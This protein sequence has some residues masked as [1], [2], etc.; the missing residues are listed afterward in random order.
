MPSV[1]AGQL[2]AGKYLIEKRLGEGGMG[3]V[4]AARHTILNQRVAIKLMHPEHAESEEAVARFVREGQ[5]AARLRSQHV[6]RVLDVGQLETGIPFLVMDF[7][8]GSDL[9]EV[10]DKRGP[11]PVTNAVLFLLQACEAVAEAH[12]LGIV[13]RD[14]KPANLFLT[15]DAYGKPMV[16]VLDFGISKVLSGF[17][18]ESIRTPTLTA[19][20]AVMGSPMYMPPEQ[21][22]S[23]R[24]ADA[25]SDIWALGAI[26]YE[27]LTAEHPWR[28]ESLQEI[29]IRIGTDPA[30]SARARRGEVPLEL[31]R[32]I[33]HCLEKKPEQRYQRVTELARDLAP[34]GGPNAR[35]LLER[36]DHLGGGMASSPPRSP[37]DALGDPT[38]WA[39]Y[40]TEPPRHVDPT[41]RATSPESNTTAPLNGAWVP[42]APARM[43]RHPETRRKKWWPFVGALC[44]LVAAAG[45]LL[46]RGQLE[47]SRTRAL[48][49]S[50]PLPVQSTVA[51]T[52]APSSTASIVKR[53]RMLKI[54]GGTFSMGSN[55]GDADERPVHKVILGNFEVD[56]TE[57]TVEQYRACARAGGCPPAPTTATPS[58][59]DP[60][61]R[62]WSQF[63]NSARSG[64]EKHPV[65]CVDWDQA[66]QYCKWAEK[67][68][69][70]EEEWEYAV[71]GTDGR[72]YSW[73]NDPPTP[74]LLNA[75]GS[76]CAEVGRSLGVV[77]KALYPGNDGYPDTAPVASYASG[78]T[79]SG[80]YD[81]AGNVWEWT[82]SQYCNSYAKGR[83]C[84]DSRVVRGGGW[85]NIFPGT[86]RAAK[87]LSDVPSRR[88]ILLGFRCV[89]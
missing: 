75:C 47:R 68:L 18:A 80:L 69:P 25:R 88:S 21:M 58:A 39:P 46:G 9:S 36:I 37:A 2:L 6:G 16:K 15:T 10:V 65:N 66:T 85:L 55:D 73:G 3:F 5:S 14:L 20:K 74:Q 33:L 61:Q 83:K 63:C 84:T 79:P 44:A 12:T 89:R 49:N 76:E 70:T 27:L 52:A 11:L 57:V 45:V 28:G 59:S 29:C 38:E 87:R 62:L 26:L 43:P 17:G 53:S 86:V 1:Q 56:E 32:C 22:V 24:S 35:N 41:R 19:T 48:A 82:A 50:L 64:R 81:M 7:L 31:D 30:P 54:V 71:R 67:R 42:P 23:T 8:D 13:H 77:W 4:L 40:G 51:P 78:R 72:T 34:F 60:Q